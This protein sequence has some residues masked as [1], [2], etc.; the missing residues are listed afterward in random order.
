MLCQDWYL[1]AGRQRRIVDVL[2][3]EIDKRD[4]DFDAECRD[5]LVIEVRR[6]IGGHRHRADH[7]IIDITALRSRVEQQIWMPAQ[8]AMCG[9]A[10][11]S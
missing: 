9:N 2:A 10:G 4:K 6:N 1:E 7:H 8:C 5:R 3:D 11:R